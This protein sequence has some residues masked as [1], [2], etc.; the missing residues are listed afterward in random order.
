[1]GVWQMAFVEEGCRRAPDISGTKKQGQCGGGVR[2]RST[3]V[4]SLKGDQAFGA[5]L[6]RVGLS[7]PLRGGMGRTPKSQAAE[8]RLFEGVFSKKRPIGL[9][10]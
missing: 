6:R 2:K 8:T 7:M 5:V 4:P 10:Y 3:P 1:M 9:S